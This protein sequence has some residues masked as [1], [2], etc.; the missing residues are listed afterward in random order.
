MKKLSLVKA[1]RP[2]RAASVFVLAMSLIGA[3]VYA[4]ANRELYF[5]MFPLPANV[6]WYVCS[7]VPRCAQT[8]SNKKCV[9]T[10]TTVSFVCKSDRDTRETTKC[11]TDVQNETGCG[12]IAGGHPVEIYPVSCP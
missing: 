6:G 3:A 12:S 2:V 8:S 10:T 9:K 7:N 4:C 5:V 1:W 11:F